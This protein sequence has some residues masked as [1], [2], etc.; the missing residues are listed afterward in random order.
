MAGTFALNTAVHTT[1][2]QV[3]VALPNQTT[4]DHQKQQAGGTVTVPNVAA[5]QVL[6]T[7]TKTGQPLFV[8]T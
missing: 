4:Y 3:I 6:R 7:L 1:L 2:T 8:E 5:Q